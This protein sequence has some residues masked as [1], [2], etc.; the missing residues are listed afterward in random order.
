[1]VFSLRHGF[2]KKGQFFIIA[3]IIIV[4]SIFA[5]ANLIRLPSELGGDEANAQRIKILDYRSVLQTLDKLSAEG[6]I[7][8]LEGFNH[9]IEINRI[10]SSN[11]SI[12]TVLYADIRTP[13]DINYNSIFISDG[14]KEIPY[15]WRQLNETFIRIYILNQFKTAYLFYNTIFENIPNTQHNFYISGLNDSSGIHVNSSSYSADVN[16]D[17]SMSIKSFGIYRTY[18]LDSNMGWVCGGAP[19]SDTIQSIIKIDQPLAVRVVISGSHLSGG[20][21]FTKYYFFFPD[22]ILIEEEEDLSASPSCTQYRYNIKA[23]STLIN[24]YIDDVGT[25]PSLSANEINVFP[26]NWVE[27]YGSAINPK[28]TIGIIF[29]SPFKAYGVSSSAGILNFSAY[30]FNQSSIPIGTYLSKVMVY[31]QTGKNLTNTLLFSQKSVVMKPKPSE[32]ANLLEIIKILS[33]NIREKGGSLYASPEISPIYENFGDQIGWKNSSLVRR[34][35]VDVYCPRNV[36]GAPVEMALDIDVASGIAVYDGN[37]IIPYQVLSQSRPYKLLVIVSCSGYKRLEVY[38]NPIFGSLNQ[39]PTDLS[40]SETTVS[41]SFFTWNFTAENFSYKGSPNW[42]LTGWLTCG[43]ICWQGLNSTI[44]IKFNETGPIRAI[45][46]ATAN[47]IN[48][49]YIF[50]FYSLLPII[51]VTM[52]S[53]TNISFGPMWGVN[54]VPNT[55]FSVYANS[56]YNSIVNPGF[57]SGTGIIPENWTIATNHTRNSDRI[58]NGAYSLKSN[59]TCVGCALGVATMSAPIPVSPNT[60]YTLSG[61]VFNSLSSGNAYLD[62]NNIPEQCNAV[63][64]LGK[65]T[66]ERISCKFTTGPSRTSVN[67]RIVT[68]GSVSGNAWFDDISL[69]NAVSNISKSDINSYNSVTYAAEGNSTIG[70]ALF[71]DV[72]DIFNS[73]RSFLL[74]STTIQVAAGKGR[75]QRTFYIYVGHWDDFN[76][77]VYF[78]ADGIK[79]SQNVWHFNTT[80]YSA[81]IDAHTSN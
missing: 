44:G 58:Y 55:D 76:P 61:E 33:R 80:Y 69:I 9:R 72:N 64:T 7:S 25:S 77:F 71:A 48:A 38:Y 19:T 17:G 75:Q 6:I 11:F 39:Y 60:D 30:V 53:P 2:G 65:N 32:D 54:G 10:I 26:Q 56:S 22:Q 29:D 12:P 37:Y 24:A 50:E 68:N 73:D 62:L 52:I 34:T 1:M 21:N 57:E 41:N 51:K 66:W 14:I 67:V 63:S 15:A 78:L 36:G 59:Y 35:F 40:V 27:I 31:P 79:A 18:P 46:N 23:N 16:N 3:T 47:G 74:N 28:P 20:E 8:W 70:W 42:F 4:T 13:S 43:G 5:V 81:Y 49:T 45:A